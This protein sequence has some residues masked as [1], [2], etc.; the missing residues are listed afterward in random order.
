M[1]K[2]IFKSEKYLKYLLLA[3]ISI[4]SITSIL[5][6]FNSSSVRT[7]FSGSNRETPIYSVN[8]SEKK[9]AITFDCAWGA[10]DIP[11]ILQTLKKENIKATFFIVGQWAEKY[12]DTVRMIFQDGH[13]IANHSYSHLRMGALDRGRINSEIQLCGKKLEELVNGKIELFRPPYGDYS[14]NVVEA[15]RELGYYTIQ[16]NVDS[17]DWK[18]DISRDEILARIC[19][20][21]NPGSIMLFHNDTAH[22]AHML[23]DIISAIKGMGYELLPVSE[24]ILRENYIIDFEGRQKK[25]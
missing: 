13:D 14:N 1:V 4:I 21:I 20:K 18:P 25:K 19:T 16:W 12:P 5:L 23:P 15:A 6:I 10:D 2:I 9:A 11:E 17:L 22:T 3:A 7:V 8:C 24:L